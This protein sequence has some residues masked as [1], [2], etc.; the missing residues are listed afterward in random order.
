VALDGWEKRDIVEVLRELGIPLQ[1]G[2]PSDR[3]YHTALCPF[4]QE[5]NPSFVV[6]E[7]TQKCLCHSCWP[8]GGDVI[9]FVRKYKDLSF[10]AALPIACIPDS[11]LGQAARRA[12]EFGKDTDPYE[13][14]RRMIRDVRKVRHLKGSQAALAL[15]AELSLDLYQ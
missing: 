3:P 9:D 8:E 12:R 6:Y 5:R 10:A 1:E 13:A 11:P 15:L 2:P 14:E 7:T 4:H